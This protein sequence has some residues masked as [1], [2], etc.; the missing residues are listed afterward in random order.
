MSEASLRSI[1]ERLATHG[2]SVEKDAVRRIQRTDDPDAMLDDLLG[3]VDEETITITEDHVELAISQTEEVSPASTPRRGEAEVAVVHDMTGQSTGTGDYDD[4][5]ALFRDRYDRLRQLLTDRVRARSITSL[6]DGGQRHTIG[7]IGMVTDIRSTANGHWML[8]LEDRTGQCRALIHADNDAHESVRE[9]LMD[10][11]IGI[12]GT[13]SDDGELVFVDELFH[14]DIPLSNESKRADRHVE[15][16]LVSDLHIGSQE[17][18]SDAW[19]AFADWLHTDEAEAVEYLLIAG[20]MVDGVGIYPGQ[21]EELSIVDVYEQ[22]AAFTEELKTV[23]GDL[24]I[25]IIPGNHDAVR[26]AEPQPGFDAELRSMLAV[27]GAEVISNPGW[28]DLEGVSVLMYHGTSLDDVIAEV[29]ATVADYTRPDLAMRLLLQ[30]RHLAPMFGSRTRIAPEER[31]YLV[32]DD[33]PDVFHAGHTHTLGVS[34]YRDVSIIN[35]ASWQHQTPFQRR[36][37]I[38]P[39]VGVAPIVDL[40]TLEVTVRSFT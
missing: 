27:H 19:R 20:D 26:L 9:I 32:I 39:D 34:S 29:P 11:V 5:V 18:A 40:Q 3:S 16:A 38:E 6:G 7:V 23:P 33:I 2:Y 21:A 12:Q 24:E 13:L 17:F 15:A 14:P 28:V 36:V 22:Y 8:D 10:E 4:F 1:V 25:V 30:K 35:S 31:D 37:N